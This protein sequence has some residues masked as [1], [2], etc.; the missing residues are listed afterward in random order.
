MH[1]ICEQLVRIDHNLVVQPHLA[2]SWS[3]S[4]D[5]KTWTF[6]IRQGITFNNGAPFSADDVVATFQLLLD[7]KT[8]S[9]ARSTLTYLTPNNVEKVDQSTVRFHLDRAV[10]VFPYD[11]SNYMI[12]ML[13]KG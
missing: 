2:E 1:Q 6:K 8:A 3:A 5:A 11:I 4:P 10:S 13:P 9:S 7:P 12:V